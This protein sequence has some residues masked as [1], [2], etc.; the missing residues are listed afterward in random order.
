MID[1]PDSL[2]RQ[3]ESALVDLAAAERDRDRAVIAQRAAMELA[4]REAAD[5]AALRAALQRVW[6]GEENTYKIADASLAQSD[7]GAALLA[8]LEAARAV[9]AAAKTL[10]SGPDSVSLGRMYAALDAYDATMK[11]REA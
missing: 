7:A 11:A 4:A 10:E 2:S 6:N 3:L 5:A 1:H 9:V 8:E